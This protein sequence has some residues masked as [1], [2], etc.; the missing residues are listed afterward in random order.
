MKVLV[1]GGTGVMG[2][3]LV[4]LLRNSGINTTITSRSYR[5]SN[6]GINY[7]QGDAQDLKFLKTMLNQ[8]WDIIVDF[9]VY[10]TA[11]F[12]E[13]VKFLLKAT[14]QY[15]FISTARVYADS[16]ESLKETS[17]RLLDVLKDKQ[18]LST[19]EYSLTKARQEDILKNSGFLN[20]TIIRPYITYSEVRFQLGVLEKED[21]LYRAIKGRKIVFSKDII[22]K[23]TT[24]THGLDVAKAIYAVL[25][26]YKTFGQIFHVTLD[27][28][29]SWDEIL[30]IYLNNLE[31]HLGFRPKVVL[32]ETDDFLKHHPAKYQMLYDR[33]YDRKFDNSKI[34]EYVEISE[35]ISLED[36]IKKSLE[37]FF[38]S[39]VFK[40]INWRNEALKDRFSKDTS[41]LSEM[42]SFKDKVKYI[43]FRYL[44]K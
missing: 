17:K 12:E 28:V 34:S 8:N 26:N 32:Q 18:F 7:I 5:K 37:E 19:D 2:V 23:L 44:K 42:K 40:A 20:W 14:N 1:L 11:D 15:I 35:F 9:M 10:S 41:S 43:V 4:S 31:K 29:Y 24:L 22:S 13:R 39:P 21:W 25:G 30:D 36:G 6:K 33:M 27:R 38:K 16:E 3:H